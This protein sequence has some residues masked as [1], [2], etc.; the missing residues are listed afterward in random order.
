MQNQVIE[1][2]SIG[3]KRQVVPFDR[4]RLRFGFRHHG[5]RYSLNYGDR[6]DGNPPLYDI[7]NVLFNGSGSDLTVFLEKSGFAGLT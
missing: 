2:S 3:G 5:P 6:F 1:D 4:G 7:D